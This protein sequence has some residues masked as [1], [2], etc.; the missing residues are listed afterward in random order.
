VTR[1][2]LGEYYGMGN[3]LSL[4][5][6]Q[7]AYQQDK[8]KVRRQI[9]TLLTLYLRTGEEDK[10]QAVKDIWISLISKPEEL[11]DG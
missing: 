10:L 6:W 9:Q 8:N 5:E 1:L 11:D 2:N 7:L 4:E 3:S